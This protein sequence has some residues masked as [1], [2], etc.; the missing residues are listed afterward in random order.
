MA[1]K[2]AA[3]FRDIYAWRQLH[4]HTA[5]R[6]KVKGHASSSARIPLQSRAHRRLRAAGI[7]QFFGDRAV[8]WIFSPKRYAFAAIITRLVHRQGRSPSVDQARVCPIS[9]VVVRPQREL[10]LIDV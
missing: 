2:Q 5:T 4:S 9:T 3:S 8:Q 6:W 1:A 10:R 7:G